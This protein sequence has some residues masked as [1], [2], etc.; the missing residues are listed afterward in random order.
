MVIAIIAIL[1]ALLVPAV[2]KVRD[3]AARTQ[4]INNLK[5]IGLALHN[6]ESAN[7]VFPQGRNQFPKVVSAHARLLAY[8]EQLNLQHLVNYD[9]TLADP[10]NVLASKT[11]VRMFLCPSDPGN[12]QVPGMT[13]FGT[14]YVACNGTGAALDPLGNPTGYFTIATGNGIFVQTAPRVAHVTDGLSNTAAFS[15]STIGNGAPLASGTSPPGGNDPTPADCDG[16]NGTW[17]VNRGGMW[18]NGHFGNTL[19]NHFYTPN[20]TKWDCGNGSH[21]KGLVSA[22]SYHLGGVNL[23]LAD[24]AVRFVNNNVAT[25]TWRALATRAGGE[26]FG[27][28]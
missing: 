13:D 15:E 24:G 26:T 22:R 5:Q 6:Y 27:D 4:C 2:Q 19:Y 9:G 10:Q 17:A 7:N 8:I 28:Y 12:G 25:A 20:S 3:A 21:N 16:M 14:N 23:L 1:I 11:Q 18:I